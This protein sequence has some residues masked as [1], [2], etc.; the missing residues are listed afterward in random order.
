MKS[1]H[2]PCDGLE[3]ALCPG[4]PGTCSR[5][6]SGRLY[7]PPRESFPRFRIQGRWRSR[8]TQ[9]SRFGARDARFHRSWHR[10]LV[11][12]QPGAG[13]PRDGRIAGA[14]PVAKSINAPPPGITHSL[15]TMAS[16]RTQELGRIAVVGLRTSRLASLLLARAADGRR[17]SV[18]RV[19]KP[20]SRVAKPTCRVKGSAFR[21]KRSACRPKSSA[22][23]V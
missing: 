10:C 19:G 8:G 11:H 21:V 17:E 20:A 5:V 12:R 4:R 6:E 9:P 2:N 1:N 16:S 14:T 23:G 3:P 18:I 7:V 13:P 15:I 22:H